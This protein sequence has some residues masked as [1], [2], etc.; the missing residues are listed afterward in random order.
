M[1]GEGGAGRPG[2]DRGV[3]DSVTARH[4]IPADGINAM[5]GARPT[6]HMVG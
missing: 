1:A 2:G 4:R 5:K 3:E 6:K